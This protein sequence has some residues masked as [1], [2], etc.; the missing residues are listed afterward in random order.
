[1]IR[2]P[3][4]TDEELSR[5]LGQ[6]AIGK[7]DHEVYGSRDD[8]KVYAGRGCVA[9]AAY[10]LG[11][12]SPWSMDTDR[13]ADRALEISRQVVPPVGGYGNSPSAVLR[14]LERKGVA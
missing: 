5:V 7:L 3:R 8:D 6:A 1:M 13:E 14:Y 11:D 2:K 12:V 10:A 4:L 9:G